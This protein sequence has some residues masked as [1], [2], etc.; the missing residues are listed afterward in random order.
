[1]TDSLASSRPEQDTSSVAVVISARDRRAEL[2]VTLEKLREQSYPVAEM[3]VVDD[4]SMTSLESITRKS[5]PDAFFIRNEEPQGYIANRS[6]AMKLATSEFIVSLDDDSCFTDPHDLAR[7]VS[8]MQAEPEIGILNFGVYAGAGPVPELRF[9]EPE[10]YV[11]SFIGCAHMV[12]RSVVSRIGGYRDYYFYYGEESEYSLRVWDAGW[13]ILFLP[14]VLVHHRVSSVGRR[15]GRILGFSIRNNLW[16]TI[17]HMPM[18][19]VAIQVTWRV[20]SYTA[21]SIRLFRP[22]AWIWGM[23]SFFKG[24]PHIVRLRKPIRPET[25]ALLDALSS[26][27]ICKPEDLLCTPRPSFVRRVAAFYAAW[28]NRPRSRSFWDRRRGHLGQSP[29]VLFEQNVEAP[30]PSFHPWGHK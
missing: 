1:M 28:K 15:S 18:P 17:L 7:A 14:S 20:V 3:I 29:T 5:W 6:R 21:E 22:R 26:G 2:D 10:H 13:R 27:V 8:R 4:A 30:P 11:A 12:R 24:L 16:T 25:L 23:Y 9:S 19:R